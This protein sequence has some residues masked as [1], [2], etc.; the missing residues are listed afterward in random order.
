VPI[1]ASDAAGKRVEST[2]ILAVPKCLR[3]RPSTGG[4]RLEITKHLR[5]EGIRGIS[6]TVNRLKQIVRRFCDRCAG[7][8][9]GDAHC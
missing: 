1:H 5:F 2:G 3:E 9:P 7:L 8:V 6:N 4:S